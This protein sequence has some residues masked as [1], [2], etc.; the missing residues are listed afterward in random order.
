MFR[1]LI[2]SKHVSFSLTYS[3]INDKKYPWSSNRVLLIMPEY[4]NLVA[5]GCIRSQDKF[6]SADQHRL[7]NSLP[8][9]E[10]SIAFLAKYL[11]LAVT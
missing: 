7:Q 11:L 2:F 8:K 5:Y 6:I 3:V 1:G 9:N 4:L 10:A